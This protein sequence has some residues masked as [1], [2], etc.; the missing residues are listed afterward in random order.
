MLKLA[1]VS[2]NLLRSEAAPGDVDELQPQDRKGGSTAREVKNRIQLAEG[3]RWAE[4]TT[5]TLEAHYAKA[6]MLARKGPPSSQS[7]T[8]S[9]GI[10]EAACAN[11]H[12]CH[13]YTSWKVPLG[14]CDR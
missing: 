14:I 12:N 8:R 4:L 10:L 6:K 1:W 9:R 13:K 7:A 11:V 3:G 2:L 5:K